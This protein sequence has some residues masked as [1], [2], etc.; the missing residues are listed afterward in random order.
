MPALLPPPIPLFSCSISRTSGKRSRIVSTVASLEPLS[1]TITSRP[2]TDS[3]HCSTHGSAFHVTTTTETSGAGTWDGGPPVEDVLP[4]DHAEPGEREQPGHH[5][6]QEAARERRAGDDA[7][8][9]E[10][11]RGARLPHGQPVDRSAQ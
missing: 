6:E 8:A 10:E 3:R 1:T 11:A 2:R 4:H 5:E 9:A 7:Q